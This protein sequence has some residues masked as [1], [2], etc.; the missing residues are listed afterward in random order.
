MDKEQAKKRMNDLYNRL[1]AFCEIN[2]ITE[3]IFIFQLQEDEAIGLLQTSKEKEKSVFFNFL[4]GFIANVLS[5][6]NPPYFKDKIDLTRP[7]L[8]G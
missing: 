7:D 8:F 2:G 3:S 5:Q 1:N 4:A 6:K